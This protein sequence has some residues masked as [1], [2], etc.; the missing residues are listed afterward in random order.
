MIWTEW[1]DKNAISGLRNVTISDDIMKIEDY[2]TR[3]I[4]EP[5]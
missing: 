1:I 4:D 3:K 2:K 5:N